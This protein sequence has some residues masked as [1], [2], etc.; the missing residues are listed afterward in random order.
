MASTSACQ[1]DALPSMPSFQ[2][3]GVDCSEPIQS[4][5]RMDRKTPGLCLI[6]NM[7]RVSATL[8]VQPEER[9]EDLVNRKAEQIKKTFEAMG[10]KCE[11]YNQPM[12]KQIKEKMQ[13]YRQKKQELLD[14]NCFV[15]WFLTCRSEDTYGVR[16]YAYDRPMRMKDITQPFM[17]NN[18]PEL[19]GKPKLFFVEADYVKKHEE[20]MLADMRS[21][22][23]RDTAYKL[24]ISADFLLASCMC[25][26]KDYCYDMQYA[27]NFH[28]VFKEHC[29][30]EPVNEITVMLD[31][32]ANKIRSRHEDT[33]TTSSYVSTLTRNLYLT[34]LPEKKPEPVV[35]PQPAPP[36]NV[37]RE[38][39]MEEDMDYDFP[40]GLLRDAPFFI[41][42]HPSLRRLLTRRSRDA[43]RNEDDNLAILRVLT[44]D[45]LHCLQ[46]LSETPRR[47]FGSREYGWLMRMREIHEQKS[48]IIDKL[49]RECSPRGMSR[50]GPAYWEAMPGCHR[51]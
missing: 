18:C 50:D 20:H 6:I 8:G 37:R 5:Y 38:E 25:P 44:E 9:R 49:F 21:G 19:V 30:P 16:L 47:Y 41:Y 40:R 39:R 27:E 26:K 13:E 36:Q 32:I 42:S 14:S 45:E 24:P 31:K 2:D 7:S 29:T 43:R 35:V 33:M 51:M 22:W 4:E 1:A 34:K 11:V 3:P 48:S 10:F 46:H 12:I 15:C 28:D 23:R 17:G